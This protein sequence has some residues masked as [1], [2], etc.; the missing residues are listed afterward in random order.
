MFIFQ[1]MMRVTGGSAAYAWAAE[2]TAAVNTHSASEV[3]LWVGSFGYPVGTIGWSAAVE[4][5]SELEQVNEAMT[6]D[7]N[8][9]AL[10]DRGAQYVAETSPDR[11]LS[12]VHGTPSGDTPVGSYVGMSRVIASPDRVADA[13]AAATR[14]G[15]MVTR[16]SDINVV[17]TATSAGPVN[18][19]T[20]FTAYKS[21]ADIERGWAAR[22]QSQ[23][24]ATEF[25]NA[26]K[27]FE[28][29]TSIG[30]ARRFA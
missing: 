21:S 8:L 4:H 30:Y 24:W 28:P 6:L 7:A 13:V 20:L 1:R 11:I 15:D 19:L 2:V 29:G 25:A 27:L 9:N 5:L 17:I 23:E 3:S 12:I 26:S 16:M 18:E 22:A 14:L 10:V